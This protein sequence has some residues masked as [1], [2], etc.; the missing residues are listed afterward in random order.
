MDYQA[1]IVRVSNIIKTV[2]YKIEQL[3]K[4]YPGN[5]LINNLARQMHA[6]FD[7]QVDQD[8]VH[9]ILITLQKLIVRICDFR[10]EQL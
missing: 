9:I 3:N 2:S 10:F 1:S 6:L 8:S 4:R 5:Y 7:E